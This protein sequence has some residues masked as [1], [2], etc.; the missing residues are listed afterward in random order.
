MIDIIE[1]GWCECIREP[2][3]DHGLEGYQRNE[4]YYY[5]L[6]QKSSLKHAPRNHVRV[7]LEC[8]VDTVGEGPTG[9]YDTVTVGRFL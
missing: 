3:G 8:S 5:E 1:R 2:R 4:R 6:V 9:H 7:Y